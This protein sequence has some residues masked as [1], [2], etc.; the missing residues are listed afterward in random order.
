M[1]IAIFSDTYAPQVNGV[2]RTFQRL[3]S[4]LI[5][6]KIEHR[7]FIPET[8][9][10][11]LFANTVHRFTSIPF[12]LYP[13]CRI[14]LPNMLHIR[15][16]LVEFQPDLI[17]IATP[18]NIGLSGL[19]YGKRLNIPMVGTYHTH[20]DQYLKYYDLEF[21]A[22]WTWKY[23]VWF[24]QP[25]LK[26]FVPS[27]D[28]K[29]ELVK[30]GFSNLHIWSR[31]VD[32]LLFQPFYEKEMMK[33]KFSI[34]APH[35]LTY[36]GRLAPE[37]DLHVLMEVARH[38]PPTIR[39]KIHWL[40]VGDGPLKDELQKNKPEN[41][42][43]AGYLDGENLAEVYAGSSL[44]VFP[45]ST[46]TFGNVVLESLASGTPVIGPDSGGVKEII[47]DQVTGIL[48]KPGQSSEFIESII[49]LLNNEQLLTQMGGEA[50]K[51]SLNQSW[52]SIFNQLISD[53]QATIS[54]S[55]ELKYA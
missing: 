52:D 32:C 34:D 20:F 40:I 14:A 2:A 46:E 31:G 1:K 25:F 11:D 49:K 35:V 45:S 41:M 17:H 38:L 36:V 55:Q 18:F 19:Y 29:Q 50:R 28:T 47:K 23:L 4:Y 51:F 16:Q 37:K 9:G 30:R 22:K 24:H 15:K 42:T 48:C 13:E 53:Y 10:E 3:E 39:G 33:Q 27:Q 43:F 8:K 6:K 7:L 26:N 54:Y 21:F 12:F 5:E 44:L